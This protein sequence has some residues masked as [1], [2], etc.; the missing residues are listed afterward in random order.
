MSFQLNEQELIEKVFEA[1]PVSEVHL[2][3]QGF[4]FTYVSR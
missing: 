4:P 1:I 2:V 3:A